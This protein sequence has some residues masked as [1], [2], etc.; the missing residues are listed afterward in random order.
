MSVPMFAN[1]LTIAADSP[2]KLRAV[3]VF[4]VM[5]AANNRGF[6]HSFGLWLQDQ[7]PDLGRTIQDCI[8]ELRIEG[9]E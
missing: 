6:M 4:R 7:R 5:D 9:D 3:D 2:A 8:E 1:L